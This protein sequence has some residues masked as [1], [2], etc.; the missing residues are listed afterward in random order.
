MATN[1]KVEETESITMHAPVQ[2]AKPKETRVLIKL[3]LREDDNTPGLTVDQFEHVTI[4]NEQGENTVYI[5]RGVP[6]EVTIP[7]Y[8][9][10]KQRFPDI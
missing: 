5:K 3:P 10:L 1:K 4:S 8:T 2:A 7:V 9:L 6:V